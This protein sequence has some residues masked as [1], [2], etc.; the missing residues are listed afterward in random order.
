[1]VAVAGDPREPAVFYFGSTGGGV[2]KTTDGGQY[3]GNVSDGFFK[4]ASVGGDR[5]GR[6]RPERDLRRHGRGDHPRQR[7]PRRRRLQDRPTRGQTW[8]HIGLAD[9]RHIGKVRVH[10]T[11]PDIV[12]R[13]GVRPRLRPEPRARRLPLDGR[14]RDLGARAASA[15]EHGRRHRPVAST[16]PTRASSTPVIW[17][18][19][20]G[21]YCTDQRRPGQRALSAR[22]TAATPGPS[23]RDKPGHARR[24]SRARSASRSRRRAPD[25]VWAIVEAEKGGVFRSDDGGETWERCQRGP[26]PAPARLVLQPHLSPTRSDADTVWVLNVEIWRS[27][28]GGKTFAARA[29]AARRQPR[30]VDRPARTRSG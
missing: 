8:T 20:R 18:A 30:P 7:L 3:W 29:G 21:P 13:R 12:L 27:I 28:D 14:R 25:R 2:W 11:D 4:R 1:M 9:T 16:R 24:A 22:P 26:Q 5:R 19:D 17:E 23:S 15:A 10:P 6:V